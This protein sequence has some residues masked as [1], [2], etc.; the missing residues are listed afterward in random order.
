MKH[1]LVLATALVLAGL[2]GTAAS[3]APMKF[4]Y[5]KTGGNHC[6]WWIQADG[7]IV[8][9]T[10]AAFDTFYHSLKYPPGTVRLNSLGGNLM[11]GVALGE[12]IRTLGLSTEVGATQDEA[13]KT[14]GIC[15]SACAYAFLGGKARFL[16]E[17]ARLGFHRFYSP[18]AVDNAKAKLFSGEDLDNTQK[19]LAGLL[20]YTIPKGCPGRHRAREGAG[21]QPVF[22]RLPHRPRLSS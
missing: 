2:C 20:F 3:A 22:L 13:D 7:E 8:A 9:D 18:L 12:K 14:A 21:L 11:A 6:C 4:E 17:N 19:L 1:I 5:R 16:E 15:A 10:P